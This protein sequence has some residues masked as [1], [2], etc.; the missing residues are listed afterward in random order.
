MATA[1]NIEK[2][3]EFLDGGN[4]PAFNTDAAN[5][6]LDTKEETVSP[7]PRTPNPL[8]HLGGGFW[9]QT[10]NLLGLPGEAT[11][12]VAEKMGVEHRPFFGIKEAR[13][14]GEKLKIGYSLENQPDTPAY[15]AGEYTQ[16]GLTFL[17]PI[18]RLG[19]GA[20]DAA[21]MGTTVQPSV[22]TAKGVAQRVTNPFVTNPSLAY[23]GELAGSV[24]AG[25]GSHYSEGAAPEEYKPAAAM[26]GG[27][28]SGMAV[29][30][31]I[32]SISKYALPYMKK[33]LF[34][35][36][37]EGGLMRAGDRL[38]EV[39]ETPDVVANIAKAKETIL[40]NANIT[41][42]DLSGDRH[43][44]SLKNRILSENP[45]L[46]HKL[47]LTRIE[48]D[49]MAAREAVELG[50]DV[51]V[52]RT[53]A[54]LLGRVEQINTVMEARVAGATKRAK[55]AL[56]GLPAKQQREVVHAKAKSE[57]DKALKDIRKLE[58]DA[59]HSV[60]KSEMSGITGTMSAYRGVLNERAG[61]QS[62]DPSEIP[63]FVK[64][65][66]GG[67]T[68]KGK[69]KPGKYK[70]DQSIAELTTFRGRLLR[71]SRAEKGKMDGTTNWNKARILDDLQEAVLKDISDS[72]ASDEVLY[73]L[74]VSRKKNELFKGG[75]M[76]RIM[77]HEKTGSAINP[78]VALE[79]VGTGPKAA[80]N[81]KKIL[82][83]SPESLNT[84]EDFVKLS[85]ANSTAIKGT[86]SG[87]VRVNVDQAR[88]YMLKNEDLLDMFP[89]TRNSLEK[90]ILLEEKRLQTTAMAQTRLKNVDKSTA[91]RIGRE[92][93]R[94]VM[95]K[96]MESADPE[97][98]MAQAFKQSDKI[99]RD[100]L[101]AD[102]INWLLGKSKT[103]M[104]D[105]VYHEPIPHG[106]KMAFLWADNKKAFSKV[107]S[108]PEMARMD[109]IVNTFVKNDSLTN[110]P[111]VKEVIGPGGTLGAILTR[112]V[113][114]T[115][116][117]RFGAK[118]GEGTSG[119]SL[120]TASLMTKAVNN[121][122]DKLDVGE[123][124]RLLLDSVSDEKLY[125]ALFNDATTF[126]AQKMQ[127][128][129]LHSWMIANAISSLPED[130]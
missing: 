130:E 70:S 44:I 21:K 69:F 97:K 120:R 2:A 57:L 115:G 109:K 114:G 23:S 78:E 60:D 43:L 53:Q 76:N 26:V 106:R 40:P 103:G 14:L 102:A 92:N 39:A 105:D 86:G 49:R 127:F 124:K 45:A 125:A 25:Y 58:D 13:D 96:I 51:P 15:R 67:T 75:I 55:T 9:D 66:L 52:Q 89:D 16:L 61:I 91:A 90:A 30:P 17:A 68:K 12:F 32:G 8:S 110:L 20:M 87:K 99:G 123:A 18:L 65:M 79:S 24:A 93:P 6:F 29:Q 100:G 62:A 63:V 38:R 112:I 19:K 119:A 3:G 98:E 107:M 122:M 37:K 71:E 108:P 95:S 33:S 101:R 117:A 85:I 118:L 126:A 80:I 10:L 27:M 42:A 41:P 128:R 59:W 73:A 113:A 4:K 7:A 46:D 116:A 88:K 72:S 5:S 22:G 82:D 121:M 54:Y 111:E 28:A 11:N 81:V 34:P 31:L 36:T 64:T 129:V 35:Y 50:G 1:F 77:G 56:E 83:A 74:S 104:F 48:T 84:M 94:K 47:R